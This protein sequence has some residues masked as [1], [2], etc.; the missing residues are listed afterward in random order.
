MVDTGAT[1]Y[2]VTKKWCVTHGVEYVSVKSHLEVQT[3]N[4]QPLNV[5]GT[6]S[7]TVRLSL[8]LEIDL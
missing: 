7:F 2:L 8:S 3:T 5:V 1:I 4:S 6:A